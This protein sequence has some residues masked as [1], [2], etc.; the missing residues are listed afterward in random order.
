[1]RKG[2][3]DIT[4]YHKYER[5][6]AKKYGPLL[7][8]DRDRSILDVG[9][10]NGML[11]AF[12]KNQGFAEVVGIDLNKELIEK[13]RQNR[14]IE[15]VV[16]DAQ[17]FLQKSGRKFDVIFIFNIVEHIERDR[18]VDFMTT[19]NHA[20]KPEGFVLV[21]TPNMSHIMAAGHLADDLTHCTGL[22]E[23][24]LTQLAHVA[25]FSKIIMLNQFRMQNFKGKIK[26]VLNWFIHK[27]LLY[28]RGGTKPKVFY[29]NLY[30]KIVK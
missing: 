15:F 6:Y 26:A 11:S 12:L 22:T 14:N 18:L 30:A 1:L 24:S 28:L 7:V 29:R 21:R 10:A 19:I 5:D 16:G 20:L 25:G 8:G 13:A 4:K 3:N 17:E 23:Q 2:G 27:W 9:C